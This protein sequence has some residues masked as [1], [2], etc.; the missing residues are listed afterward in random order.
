MCVVYA[1]QMCI[2]YI[3]LCISL[4]LFAISSDTSYTEGDVRFMYI[5]LYIY[6]ITLCY[7]MKNMATEN[8]LDAYI[9]CVCDSVY[10]YKCTQLDR[11]KKKVPIHKCHAI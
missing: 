6:V 3:V 5:L 7:T 10:I 4:M 9:V 11:H 1:I 2:I 8:A